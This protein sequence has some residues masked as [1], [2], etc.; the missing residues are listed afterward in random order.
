MGGLSTLSYDLD[1][2]DRK[3]GFGGG[4]GV[5]YTYF[6][7]DR[8]GL[9]AGLE[10]SLYSAKAEMV[11]LSTNY[12]AVD[13]E[14][15]S[16]DFRSKIN[17]Y[18][19]KQNSYF[20]NIPVMLQYQ[21]GTGNRFYIAGGGKIGIPVSSR[22]KIDGATFINS[23]YYEF[24]DKELTSPEF[25]GFGNFKDRNTKQDFDMKVSFMVSAE[26]GLSWSLSDKNKLYTGFYCDY[27]LNNT[28]KKN[29]NYFVEYN[30]EKPLDFH[31]NSIVNSNYAQKGKSY[32][33]TDKVIPFA[34]GVKVRLAFGN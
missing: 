21:F 3:N 25:L 19:E 11:D 34:I 2:G 12:T 31:V 5:G 32:E 30:T 26:A 10:F 18:T 22:Y 13:I 29:K 28:A 14:G 17:G 23:G 1:K 16:F 24:E 4:V 15:E 6:F 27:G 9:L 8:L 7:N 33:F 20:L